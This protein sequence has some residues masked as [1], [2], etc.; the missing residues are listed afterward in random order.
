MEPG[1]IQRKNGKLFIRTLE[2]EIFFDDIFEV[3]ETPQEI[4]KIFNEFVKCAYYEA[5][6]VG[7]QKGFED[8]EDEL[9]IDL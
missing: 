8:I 6:E 1:M 3:A 9:S 7:K 5:I 2:I 4:N